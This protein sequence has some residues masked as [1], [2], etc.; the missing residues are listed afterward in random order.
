MSVS[1]KPLDRKFPFFHKVCDPGFFNSCGN[2]VA[3]ECIKPGHILFIVP[4]ISISGGKGSK[5]QPEVRVE[6]IFPGGAAAD[7]GRL[8]V[9]SSGLTHLCVELS[10]VLLRSCYQL[11]KGLKLYP[12]VKL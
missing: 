6:K 2:V 12:S 5:T 9:S 8:K 10:A 7:D 3:S 1:L 11:F 4:G